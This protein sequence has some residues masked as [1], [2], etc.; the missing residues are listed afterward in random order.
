MRNPDFLN[1]IMIGFGFYMKDLYDKESKK[2]RSVEL[3]AS[4]DSEYTELT[5]FYL[6]MIFTTKGI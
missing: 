3:D 6:N 4:I 5:T 1:F 2:L